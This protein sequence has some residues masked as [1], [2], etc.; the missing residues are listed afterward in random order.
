MTNLLQRFGSLVPTGYHNHSQ[1]P[2]LL[3]ATWRELGSSGVKIEFW[4]YFDE[5]KRIRKLWAQLS[6][7][8][9]HQNQVRWNILV[10][11]RFQ[12]AA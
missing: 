8:H 12:Q 9:V 2:S 1:S 5:N 3:I 10:L 6:D 7:G 4:S 11:V